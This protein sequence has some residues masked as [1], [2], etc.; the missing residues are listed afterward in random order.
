MK[1]DKLSISYV[2][3]SIFQEPVLLKTW[4]FESEPVCFFMSVCPSMSFSGFNKEVFFNSD[5]M[6]HL[7]DLRRILVTVL[8]INVLSINPP[9]LLLMS[10]RDTIYSAIVTFELFSCYFWPRFD[11]RCNWPAVSKSVADSSHTGTIHGMNQLLNGIPCV[12][13]ISVQ[14]HDEDFQAIFKNLK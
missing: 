4:N 12:S 14:A 3:P 10:H 11:T 13:L 6:W 9:W 5:L 7:W 8:T 2:K 1:S